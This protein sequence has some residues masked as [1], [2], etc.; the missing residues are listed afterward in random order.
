MEPAQ[1]PPIEQGRQPGEQTAIR[2]LLYAL[3]GVLSIAAV[4][5]LAVLV[6]LVRPQP[7]S[8]VVA[9]EGCPMEISRSIYGFGAKPTD[10]LDQPLAVTFDGAGNVWISDTG[11]SRVVEFG[12]DGKL[13]RFVGDDSDTGRLHSP[14]GLSFSSDFQRLYVAD[15]TR[16]EVVVY[17][18]D[19]RYIESLPAADQGL[20]VFGPDGFSPY[21]VHVV[22]SQIVVASNDGLYFFDKSGHVVDRWGGELRGSEVGSFA[23][24]NGVAIDPATGNLYVADTLNRRVVALDGEGNVLWASGKRDE[25]GKIVGFWQLPRSVVVGPDGL[26]YVTDTFRAQDRCAGVGHIVV[27]KPTGELVS[28][29][30]A[31]GT[32][33]DSF[34]FPEK[35]AM[36]PD[37]TFGIADRENN[38]V[39]LFS[40]D[41]LP[42]ADPDEVSLY[43][44]SFVRFGP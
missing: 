32:S 12:P 13:I 39:V 41:P 36:G 2:R 22:G 27:L 23:F 5:L 31:A 42:P 24:P 43:E 21:D 33:E 6:W 29:F 44:E 3:I 35:M 17:S 9:V 20:A 11:N 1:E 8:T 19:G 15:W 25:E 26:V 4:A 7:T 38:R 16:R 28:E 37:G 40:V 10:L 34:S 18:A 14:Y 30:G